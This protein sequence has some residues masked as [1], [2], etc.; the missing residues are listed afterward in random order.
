M[1]L[2][3]MNFKFSDVILHLAPFQ[4]C[5]LVSDLDFF[6]ETVLIQCMV[7]Q[8]ATHIFKEIMIRLE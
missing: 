2:G 5:G 8:K 4:P 6:F 3:R 1:T 7:F